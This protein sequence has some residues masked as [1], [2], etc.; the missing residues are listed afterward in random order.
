MKWKQTEEKR[1]IR[2]KE[3]KHLISSETNEKLWIFK[4]DNKIYS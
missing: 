3:E 4:I 1:E 2:G